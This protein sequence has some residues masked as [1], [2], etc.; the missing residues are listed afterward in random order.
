MP[1]PVGG[2]GVSTTNELASNAGGAA[3]RAAIDFCIWA[4]DVRGWK[5]WT[6]PFV[7]YG[8][9]PMVAFVGSGLMAKILGMIR[10]DVG[11]KMMSLQ[12]ASYQLL[13]APY[14]TAKFAS[15][16]W[17]LTFVL[18]WLAVLWVFYKRGWILK[19]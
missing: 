7:I 4:I 13:Y 1:R 16:L 8:V 18:F 10:L 3:S 6:K 12:A 2:A 11:G 9:N 14:F 5:G 19:V 17:G 15:L